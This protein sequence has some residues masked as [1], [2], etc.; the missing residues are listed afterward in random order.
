MKM[1]GKWQKLGDREGGWQPWKDALRRLTPRSEPHG[2]TH[3]QNS[4]DRQRP[5]PPRVRISNRDRGEDNRADDRDEQR[6]PDRED[7]R[8]DVDRR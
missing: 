4:V 6:Q 8:E 5:K 1:T 2:R 7:K 3:Y